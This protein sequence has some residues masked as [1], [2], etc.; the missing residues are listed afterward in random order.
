MSFMY[1]IHSHR[2]QVVAAYNYNYGGNYGY[3]SMGDVDWGKRSS[4]YDPWASLGMADADWGWKKRNGDAAP[5]SAV[6]EDE[7]GGKGNDDVEKKSTVG[8]RPMYYNRYTFNKYH[9]APSSSASSDPV[10]LASRSRRPRY[11]RTRLIKRSY[12]DMG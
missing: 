3:A 11:S 6:A 8:A 5:A 7:D 2:A 12:G 1:L 10:T 9:P 4:A